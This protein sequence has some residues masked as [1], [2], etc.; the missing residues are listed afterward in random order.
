MSPPHSVKGI[1]QDGV[2]RPLETVDAARNGQAVVITFVPNGNA[3]GE[4]DTDSAG[5]EQLASLVRSCT[6]A[7]GIPDLAEQHDHYAHGKPKGQD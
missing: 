1:F 3:P 2:A 4:K 6:M 5:W 7:T